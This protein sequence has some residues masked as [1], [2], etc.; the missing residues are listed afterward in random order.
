MSATSRI[1]G[2]LEAGHKYCDCRDSVMIGFIS[3]SG[4]CM[5]TEVSH[6]WMDDERTFFD[7]Q[8]AKQAMF[9]AVLKLVD[10]IVS[11]LEDIYMVEA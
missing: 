4:F 9:V 1:L 5:E 7:I 8:A 11:A 2:K 10:D 3:D 6:D